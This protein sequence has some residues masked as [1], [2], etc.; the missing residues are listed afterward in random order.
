MPQF[1]ANL[2]L[3]FT[4][5]PF[6]DRFGAAAEAG[7]E[8]V[9]FQFPY[10]FAASEIAD[11]LQTHGLKAVLFN[12]FPGD[13]DK[14]ERGFAALPGRATEF[15]GSVLQARAYAATLGVK[16]L[17]VMSG[18]ADRRE[19]TA[20]AAYVDALRFAAEALGEA[21]VEA[22]IEP[23]NTM[24]FPGYFL[25]DFDYAAELIQRLK[26]PNLKLQYDLYHRQ[27]MRGAVVEGLEQFWPI[28][29][30]VQVASAP[31]RQEPGTGELD[32]FYMFQKLDD[33]GYLGYVGAEYRPA[34]GTLEG[35]G[36]WKRAKAG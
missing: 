1:A 11:R 4:E 19:A 24:D 28:I 26:L 33:L 15:R 30:H 12:L 17:H 13:S 29:G 31:K 5:L 25:N 27:R 16:K 7:F 9:E 34:A 14:G 8:A 6:L 20:R 35:L 23:L 10:A 2:S 22:L 36:W 18:N 32:D 3:M 21:G